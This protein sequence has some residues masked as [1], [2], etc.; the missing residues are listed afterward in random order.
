MPRK[1]AGLDVL[2]A[3]GADSDDTVMVAVFVQ[4]GVRVP[5]APLVPA[6]T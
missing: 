1:Y 5:I 3:D 4:V 2:A 6:V